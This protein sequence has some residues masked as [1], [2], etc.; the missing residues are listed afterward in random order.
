MAEILP[1]GNRQKAG[2]PKAKK[3]SL[4]VHLTPMVDL[5]FLLITF[6]VFTTTVSEPT[7]MNL[8]LP[9]DRT[10]IQPNE[11]PEGKTLNLVLAANN[12]T[13]IYN[14]NDLTHIK[15]IGNSKIALR[16]ALIEKKHELKNTYGSDS[17]MI[18]LIKPLPASSYAD[19]VNALDEMRICNIKT[20]VLMDAGEAESSAMKLQ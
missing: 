19:V 16:S 3:T 9:D 12:E 13:G 2:V 20:Y 5:G 6:F 17:G 1:N 11:A 4:R 8:V 7:A 14:G 15:N 10:N 18:V